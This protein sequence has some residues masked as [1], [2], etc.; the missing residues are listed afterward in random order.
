MILTTTTKKHDKVT[1]KDLKGIDPTVLREFWKVIEAG[2]TPEQLVE[3]QEYYKTMHP[4]KAPPPPKTDLDI[5]SKLGA[6][7]VPLGNYSYSSGPSP[8]QIVGSTKRCAVVRELAVHFDQQ[9][10]IMKIDCKSILDH[11]CL[12]VKRQPDDEVA[13]V[14]RKGDEWTLVLDGVY[15]DEV[16]TPE[17]WQHSWCEY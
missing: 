9:T 1:K 4:I 10:N 8:V 13:R 17:K 5:T 14:Q 2:C 11:K 3:I 12:P 7:F 6:V 15:Y 16:L